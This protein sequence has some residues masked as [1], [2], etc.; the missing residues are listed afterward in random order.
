MGHEAMLYGR[1]H[2]ALCV[3]SVVRSGIVSVWY[4]PRHDVGYGMLSCVTD[5]FCFGK[6]HH[7]NCG[8][9]S[10]CTVT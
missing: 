10:S 3:V 6:R 5:V 2:E 7:G 8:V 1:V 4:K 9:R